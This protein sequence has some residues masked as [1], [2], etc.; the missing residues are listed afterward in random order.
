MLTKP[1]SLSADD[2]FNDLLTWA[3]EKGFRPEYRRLQVLNRGSYGWVEF[4]ES[5]GCASLEEIHRFY[6]RQGGNLALLHVIGATDFHHE[7]LIA[8]GEHPILVD[9][10]TLFSPRVSPPEQDQANELVRGALINSVL[11]T[12]LLPHG[13]DE[14]MDFSGLG[15][16][17]GQLSP[18]GVPQWEQAATDEMRYLRKPMPMRGG[19]NRPMLDGVPVVLPDQV[20]SIGDGFCD[21]YKLLLEHRQEL[22]SAEGPL[23]A[24]AEDE[25]RVVL[26]HTRTYSHLLEESFHPDV[27]RDAI[28]RDYLLDLL[29]VPVAQYPF[30]AKVT[31]AEQKALRQ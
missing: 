13:T 23:A 7:N 20:N 26:R 28:D 5:K 2:H 10:E 29:W 16:V 19:A 30:L 15:T 1:R 25:V 21:M 31:A 4:I 27:L 17:E 9:L 18:V 6:R 11:N 8:S 12:G 24:F 3:N 22:L 14:A